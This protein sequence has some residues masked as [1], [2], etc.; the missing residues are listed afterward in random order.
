MVPRLKLIKNLLYL[1]YLSNLYT[2]FAISF[3]LYSKRIFLSG[4]NLFIKS[5]NILYD[6]KIIY[7]KKST[8]QKSIGYI[9]PKS[10]C[11]LNINVNKYLRANTTFNVNKYILS[12]VIM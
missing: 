8:G 5:E 1:L 12:F 9:G 10:F 6:L 11:F 2:K 4:Y 3:I 7:S